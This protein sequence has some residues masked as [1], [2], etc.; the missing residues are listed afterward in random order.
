MNCGGRNPEWRGCAGGLV[1]RSSQL[2]STSAGFARGAVAVAAPASPRQTRISSRR[3]ASFRTLGVKLIKLPACFLQGAQ[4]CYGR[5]TVLLARNHA[6]L[7]H[8][9]QRRKAADK[10]WV[11]LE[12]ARTRKVRLLCCS[13]QPGLLRHWQSWFQAESEPVLETNPDNALIVVRFEVEQSAE[14]TLQANCWG[15]QALLDVDH[16]NPGLSFDLLRGHRHRLPGHEVDHLLELWRE[17]VIELA[18]SGSSAERSGQGQGHI[19]LGRPGGDL[20]PSKSLGRVD[21]IPEVTGLVSSHDLIDQWLQVQGFFYLFKSGRAQGLECRY[22]CPEYPG[23]RM[24][25]EVIEPSNL[26]VQF[27]PGAA[28]HRRRSFDHWGGR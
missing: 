27:Q 15:I 10:C 5:G 13:L 17:F 18:H 12:D 20:D 22:D 6:L 16:G 9:I 21:D 25:S 26:L 11:R 24:I 7:A 8:G 28:N 1:N 2:Q 3:W 14:R 23:V 4:S 19:R